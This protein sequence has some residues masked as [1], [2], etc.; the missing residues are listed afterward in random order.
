MMMHP[1]VEGPCEET[2]EKMPQL[3]WL[4]ITNLI[5]LR[6]FFNRPGYRLRAL[7]S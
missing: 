1:G 5:S 3:L 4:V 7:R 2:M 6:L